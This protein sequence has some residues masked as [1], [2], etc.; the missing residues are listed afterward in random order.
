MVALMV[1]VI[2]LIALVKIAQDMK[3]G[4]VMVYVMMVLGVYTLIVKNLIVMQVIVL[5]INVT[6]EILME[7]E[8]LVEVMVLAQVVL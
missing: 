4:L 6:E 1:V 3:D 8:Q 5:L 7:V 2:A